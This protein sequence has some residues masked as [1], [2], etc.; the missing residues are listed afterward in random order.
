MAAATSGMRRLLTPLLARLDARAAH[1][2][3]RVLDQHL[4]ATSQ[5]AEPEPTDEAIGHSE[6]DERIAAAA[7]SSTFVPPIERL[8]VDADQP[9]MQYSTCSVADFQ[10]PRFAELCHRFGRDVRLHRKLWEFVFVV[11]H[12]ERLGALT[13]GSRG[14]GFGVGQEPLPA[15]FASTGCEIMA[16]DA[17]ADIGITTGWKETSQWAFTVDDLRNDGLCPPEQ[18]ARLV[19]Y[20][21]ADMNDIDADLTGFDFTW[22]ACCFEHL[23]SIG[24]GLDF[25]INS[26][27][28]CLRPGGVAVHTTELNMSSNNSTLESPSL[29][30]F[31]QCDLEGLIDEL[32]RRGH[33]VEQLTIAPDAHHLDHHVDLP[34]YHG[35]PHLK[36]ELA[37][38]VTTSVG[39]VIRRGS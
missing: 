39:L 15:V 3:R 5:P 4:A 31:R 23:G 20:R 32:R 21:P 24:H 27:E 12:L 33:E 17:P 14:V 35:Q 25:V 30:I 6:L 19:S 11:H 1:Q 7:A 38:H 18:F 16:T 2:A 36:L 28:R 13:A 37:G 9:F 34:P 22:S 29:S 8:Q 10:H 26:V